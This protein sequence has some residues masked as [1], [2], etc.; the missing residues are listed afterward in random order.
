MQDAVGGKIHTH[1]FEKEKGERGGRRGIIRLH[2]KPHMSF[3]LTFGLGRP[4]IHNVDEG[5][6][7]KGGGWWLKCI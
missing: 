6:N 3:F 1:A 7:G 4:A 2:F 5:K